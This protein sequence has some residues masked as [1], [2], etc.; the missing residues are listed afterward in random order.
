MVIGVVSW[1]VHLPGA[2]SLKDKRSVLRSLKD[3]L[4]NE[5]NVSVAETGH[6]DVW[7]RAEITACTVATDRRHAAS[8][9]SSADRMVASAPT[10]R[11]I[12][13]ITTFL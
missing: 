10:C 6:H 4:H 9:L 7:Q 2:A 12:D 1:E 11:I 3:R 5:F 13:S 8:V